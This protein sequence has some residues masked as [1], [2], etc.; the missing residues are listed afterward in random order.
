MSRQI[1]GSRIHFDAGD[2]SRVRQDFKKRRAVL[3]LLADGLVI[4]N[5]TADAFSE[6]WRGDNQFPIGAPRLQ[7]LRNVELGEAFVAGGIAFIH[8]QQPF[9][10]G[11]QGLR[12]IG[13]HWDVHR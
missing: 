3:L 4:K 13:Q 11:D 1:L 7:G 2:N 9:M 6:T 12:G 8:R 10:V 5:H